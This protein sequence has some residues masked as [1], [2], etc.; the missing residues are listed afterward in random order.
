MLNVVIS[1]VL[2]IHDMLDMPRE[3]GQ[4]RL[5]D[6]YIKQQVGDMSDAM[7]CH[8]YALYIYIYV[9]ICVM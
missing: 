1:S 3:W 5:L 7:L 2:L 9:E 6:V 4:Q 8:V